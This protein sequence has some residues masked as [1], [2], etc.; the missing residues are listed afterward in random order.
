MKH[1]VPKRQCDFPECAEKNEYVKRI[2]I[3]TNCFR[4]DDVVLC[5]CKEHR[6]P[7]HHKALLQT[8]KAKAQ[9]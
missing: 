2:D 7:E 6:K 5:A 9:Q 8:E 3:P 4:G 1:N